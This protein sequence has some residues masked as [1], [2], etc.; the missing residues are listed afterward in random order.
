MAALV[1]LAAAVVELDFVAVHALVGAADGFVQVRGICPPVAAEGDGQA[2]LAADQLAQAAETCLEVELFD[3]WHQH[4]ELVTAH[5]VGILTAVALREQVGRPLQ[6]FIARL[7]AARVIDLLE[8]IDVCVDDAHAAR[9]LHQR[10]DRH[11]E[12]IAV[13][14]ARQRIVAAQMI[15][16]H[17]KPV[18]R[19]LGR[20][21]VRHYLKDGDRVDAAV[22]LV[23][24]GT[25]T[26]DEPA[27]MVDGRRYEALDA[28]APEVFV[29]DRVVILEDRDVIDDDTRRRFQELFPA[30]DVL[31]IVELLQRR[32]LRLDTGGAPLKGVRDGLAVRFEEVEPVLMQYAIQIGS[33]FA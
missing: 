23:I 32:H 24:V 8:A 14:Q 1:L 19:E 28:L 15:E 31:R 18:I 2:L 9:M 4:E 10:V 30:A 27:A 21:E 12:R 7:M 17:H 6:R 22:P 29:V 20:D 25:E 26:A 16:L 5:A 13:P 33:P 3:E 11:A